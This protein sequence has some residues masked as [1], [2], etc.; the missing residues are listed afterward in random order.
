MM[1]DRKF[2]WRG[3][4]WE[5][6]LRGQTGDGDKVCGEDEDDVVRTGWG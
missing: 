5:Q 3:L 6:D 4:G 2:F 1:Q